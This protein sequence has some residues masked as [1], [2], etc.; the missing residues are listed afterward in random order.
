[1]PGGRHQVQQMRFR[2]RRQRYLQANLHY[3]KIPP[4][5]QLPYGHGQERKLK[6]AICYK[7][8]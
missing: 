8:Y 1:M 2:Q 5:N 7:H 4:C 6:H 3:E